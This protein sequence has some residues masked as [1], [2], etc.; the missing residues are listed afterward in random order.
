MTAI[1]ARQLLQECDRDAGIGSGRQAKRREE[2]CSGRRGR[3]YAV[4][5]DFC[6]G[7]D[8]D[9]YVGATEFPGSRQVAE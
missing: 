9:R 5:I 4:L 7:G 3:A 2:G 1:V 8:G 6:R